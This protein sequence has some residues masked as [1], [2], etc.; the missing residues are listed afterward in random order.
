LADRTES[1]SKADVEKLLM[2]GAF[3]VEP[4]IIIFSFTEIARE[5][6]PRRNRSY[7]RASFRLFRFARRVEFLLLLDTKTPE[8]KKIRAASL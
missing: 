4:R 6:R 2:S 8:L 3:P 7:L 5:S 1:S